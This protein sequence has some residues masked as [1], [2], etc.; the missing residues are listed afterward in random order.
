MVRDK[1]GIRLWVIDHSFLQSKKDLSSSRGS[2]KGIG[3][4][5]YHLSLG[6]AILSSQYDFE[7]QQA[8]I[9]FAGTVQ[10]INKEN[11]EVKLDLV[12]TD[13]PI[14]PG[15]HGRRYW[16][17][18][19]FA[20]NV[21]K[22]HF[23]EI[24]KLLAEYLNDEQWLTQKFTDRSNAFAISDDKPSLHVQ[25]GFVY[26]WQWKNEYK[27]GKAVDVGRRMKQVSQKTGR[28]LTEIHRIFSADYTQAEKSLHK[29]FSEKRIYD[30]PGIEW[31]ALE[32]EDIEWLKGIS[33][34]E[35]IDDESD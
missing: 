25:E 4:L 9:N 17:G 19:F 11:E 7:E 1:E 33:V 35:H 10:E 30:A 13:F 15:P 28:K 27:I 22:I 21:E 24:P 16:K 29:R 23:Y 12:P 2:H 34:F 26:I 3:N 6:D 5:V 20:L 31:F 14:K 32:P 8:Q 18:P